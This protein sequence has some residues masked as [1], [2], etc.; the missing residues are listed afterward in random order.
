MKK[1]KLGFIGCGFMGQL[2]HLSNYVVSEHCEVVALCDE[3]VEQ[4]KLV[5]TRYGIPKVYT[6]YHE[7]LA[8]SEIEGIV[9]SQPFENHINLVPDILRAKKHLLTEKPLCI[10]PENGEQLPRLAAENGVIH[11]IGYHKRS[12]PATDYAVS[13]IEEWKNTGVMGKMK[14]VRITMPPGDWIGGAKGA[15]FSEESSKEFISEQPIPSFDLSTHNEMVTFVNYYIHQVNY[16]RLILGEDFKLAYVDRSQVM[17]AVESSGGICG[18][19]ETS[20]YVTTDAWQEKILVAFEKGW[21]EIEL[22]APLVT[23]QAGRVTCFD[24]SKEV[25]VLTSPRLP[26]RCAMRSQSERFLEAIRGV[27]EAPCLSDEALKDLEFSV[28]YIN[29]IHNNKV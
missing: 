22:P 6:D 27:K 10:Y 9:A 19:I 28:D 8:D 29:Y 11:M 20:P 1:V 4:A 16:M 23:Q 17:M 14:Y 25:G 3:K 2:A 18:V 5:A 21:I 26:N 13:V 12:D 24:N 7:L 15:L